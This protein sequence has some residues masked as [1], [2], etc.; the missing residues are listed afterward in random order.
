MNLDFNYNTVISKAV[1]NSNYHAFEEE[2][3]N[4]NNNHENLKITMVYIRPL[5]AD[6][7]QRRFDLK[8]R[9]SKEWLQEN[10][11]L[12]SVFYFCGPFEF[13]RSII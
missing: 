6:E 3:K 5:L 11:N 12:N 7:A 9:L 4:L 10:V 1:S 2:V 8:G 13:M